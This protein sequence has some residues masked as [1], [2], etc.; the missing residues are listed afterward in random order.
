MEAPLLKDYEM[1]L[2]KY[3]HYNCYELETFLAEK[4][5][6]PNFKESWDKFTESYF[7]DE[8]LYPLSYEIL[9][10]W[11][12]EAEEVEAKTG[13]RDEERF[14][15]FKFLKKVLDCLKEETGEESFNISWWW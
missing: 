3:T 4:L 10:E 9:E 13:E 7:S 2:K 11:R 6:D 14:E 15:E 12:E 8:G 5:N 1:K